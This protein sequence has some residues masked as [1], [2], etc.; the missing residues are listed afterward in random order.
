MEE[1]T[2]AREKRMRKYVKEKKIGG[3]KKEKGNKKKWLVNK[4]AEK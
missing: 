4:T 1:K 2:Y 3:R